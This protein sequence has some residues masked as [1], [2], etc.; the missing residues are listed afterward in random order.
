MLQNHN[1][2]VGAFEPEELQMLQQVLEKICDQR[3]ILKSSASAADIAA[4]VITLSQSG[5]WGEVQLLAMLT[6]SANAAA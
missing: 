1:P 3:G 5:F 4:D 6:S 2:I